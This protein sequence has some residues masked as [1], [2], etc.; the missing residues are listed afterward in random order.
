MAAGVNI[1][2]DN[3]SEKVNYSLDT[4]SVGRKL[5]E[6]QK[7][8]FKDSKT[9]DEEGNLL[10]NDAPFLVGHSGLSVLRLSALHQTPV[11]P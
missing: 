3:S 9:L 4:D 1:Y 11:N 5:S 6:G 10:L 8:Y 7:E 2:K